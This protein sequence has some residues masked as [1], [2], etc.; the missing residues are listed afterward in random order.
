MSIKSKGQIGGGIILATMV[1]AIAFASVEVNTIRFG[2]PIQLANQQLSDLTAD[3]LPP[4]EYVIESYLEATKLIDNPAELKTRSTNLAKLEKDF[5]DR[6]AYWQESSLDPAL[7][8]VLIDKAGADA[9]RFY[10]ELDQQ[11]LPAIAQGNMVAARASYDRLSGIY[12]SHRKQIDSLVAAT[13]KAQGELSAASLSTLTTTIM[14]LSVLGALVVSMLIGGIVFIVRRGLNPLANTA[15]VMRKMADGDFDV[16]VTGAD[17]KDEIGTMVGAVE[18]F[19]AASKAQ[20]EGEAKQRIVVAELAGGLSQLATGNMTHRITAPFAPEYVA[21][22]DSF[23]ETVEGLADIMSRVAGSASSVHT[24]ASEIRA[25]SDDLAMRTEQ[26]A[27]S[28]EETAAAM[29]QVTGMVKE[30]AKSASQVNTSIN[31]AHR[32]ATEGGAVVA[33]AVTAMDAIERSAQEISQIINVIDGIAFQTNLLALNA[34]VEAA[35]AGDAGKGFAVVANEVRALA[36]RSAD[37]AKDIKALITTSSKQVSEGVTL[38]GETGHMLGR[39]V[40][41]VGDISQLITGI[42]E[43]AEIQATNLQQVNGAVGEM[44][45]MT[46]QNAAMVEESTAAAR[47]LAGEADELSALVARFQTGSHSGA[48]LSRVSASAPARSAQ[49]RAP[50]RASAP[51]VHG[52]LAIK[53]DVNDE[54]WTEF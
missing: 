40:T 46:Q 28:L 51:V 50:Q 54:D 45:K 44:D 14:L 3:I 23:N 38:V 19:R 27:A 34:G 53:A 21:L 29:S 35:R 8:S 36:Q 4:P 24:G 9:K 7:K 10:V 12:G 16:V 48:A 42:A 37:A 25:A 43:S 1:A 30:T 13:L 41:R 20:A 17:R 39:I 6:Q 26:Q 52:N 11:F 32:E 18:V 2:G 5:N 49:R 33:Q 47:S 15:D 31:E 22:R